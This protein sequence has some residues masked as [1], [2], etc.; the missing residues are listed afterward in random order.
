MLNMTP[1]VIIWLSRSGVGVA[2]SLLQ[3]L[4]MFRS[5]FGSCP[6]ILY[7][8]IPS[9]PNFQSIAS[10]L[11]LTR[12][13]LCVMYRLHKTSYTSHEILL[14]VQQTFLAYDTRI[15]YICAQLSFILCTIPCSLSSLVTS[16]RIFHVTDHFLQLNMGF[17]SSFGSFRLSRYLLAFGK[18][19]I[20]PFAVL[21][22]ALRR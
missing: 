21:Y 20:R 2:L 10:A 6:Y 9:C 22:M 13:C 1:V 15:H 19:V 7:M 8:F 18:S 16:L 14:L 5:Q 3:I 11:F 12:H 4:Y 17:F